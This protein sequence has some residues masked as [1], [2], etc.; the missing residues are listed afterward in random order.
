[1][2]TLMVIIVVVWALIRIVQFVGHLW[3]RANA[4]RIGAAAAASG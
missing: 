4:P 3:S 1:M 2:I